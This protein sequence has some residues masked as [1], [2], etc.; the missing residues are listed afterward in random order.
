MTGLTL[1]PGS[2]HHIVVTVFATDASFY[3]NGSFIGGLTLEGSITDSPSRD[4]LLGQLFPCELHVF[5]R[6]LSAV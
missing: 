2:W 1:E 6:E 5:D 3:I 4:V